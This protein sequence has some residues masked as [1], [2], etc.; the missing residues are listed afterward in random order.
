MSWSWLLT[1]R[2][3][4]LLA[5]AAAEYGGGSKR[6]AGRDPRSFLICRLDS[7]GDVVMTTPLFRELKRAYP[8]CRCTVLVR[9]A[10]RSL[11]VTNPNID[12]VLALPETRI[13]W[14]PHGLTRLLAAWSVWRGQLRRREFD[15]AI[16]PRWETDGDLGTMLCVLSGAASRVGYTSRVSATK[17][18]LNRGFDAAFTNCLPAGPA[19]HEVLRSLAIVEAMGGTVQDD[20]LD[21]H[22]TN[23][24]RYVAGELL[25]TAQPGS[26]L[27][28]LGIGAGSAGRCWPLERYA[29]TILRLSRQRRVQ[30]VVVCSADERP[31]AEEL[32][33]MIGGQ[34]IVVCGA[35]LREV[36]AVLER[37]HLFLGN[38]S[39][40]GHLAA[41]M[42]CRTIVVSRHPRQG[43]RDHA[44][45]PVRFAPYCQW[46]RVL[47]P[48]EG[49]DS[50]RAECRRK[51]PHCILGVPVDAVVA[52]ADEFLGLRPAM[53]QPELQ[54]PTPRTKK[55]W[56]PEMGRPGGP[57]K[58]AELS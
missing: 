55:G 45:S 20:H 1:V 34:T 10:Y 23:R 39:G 56:S 14:L 28:A 32:K 58:P 16:S 47:Q 4:T 13:D 21:I 22:L 30:P 38:D 51:E 27:I 57:A 53:S 44:N 50:C 33:Q 41:A 48:A 8:D 19:R 24:D 29:E 52:A 54:L 26:K 5:I 7:L 40:C 3:P 49:R 17:Q 12:S 11:L 9:G 31:Q 2:L 25:A 6:V 37:C 15:V 35:A 46:S 43:A 18:K 36:C 42:N